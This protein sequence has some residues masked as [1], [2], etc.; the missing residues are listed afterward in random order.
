MSNLT[1]AFA[2]ILPPSDEEA[3]RQVLASWFTASERGSPGDVDRSRVDP[4]AFNDGRRRR[5]AQAFL[6]RFDRGTSTVYEAVRE[7]VDEDLRE[8]VGELGRAWVSPVTGQYAAQVVREKAARRHDL[9]QAQALLIATTENDANAVERARKAL[10]SPPPILGESVALAF[11]VAA[12]AAHELCE[13]VK[14]GPGW[15]PWW[16]DALDTKGDGVRPGDYALIAAS[17]KAG[18][19]T[20]A[21][22]HAFDTAT[23]IGP[24][25]FLSYEMTPQQ[26]T[27]KLLCRMTGLRDPRNQGLTKDEAKMVRE[28]ADAL[29]GVPIY[30]PPNPPRHIRALVP[31]LRRV[32]ATE[33]PV[34][35][36]ID[37]LGLI[38]GPGKSE[39][40][41]LSVIS[42]ELRG[43]AL[44]TG[45]PLIVLHQVNR[46]AVRDN[47]GKSQVPQLHHLRGSGQLEQDATHVYVLWNAYGAATQSD[48]DAGRVT[49]GETWLVCRKDRF[50]PADGKVVMR[51]DGARSRLFPVETRTP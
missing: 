29:E 21:L 18:K 6:A 24:T 15:V 9:Q 31:W 36:Y 5:I 40:E 30:I 26:L 44:T 47:A 10:A 39:Y 12:E 19:T 17:T 8:M 22:G 46:D 33:R 3:E 50:G 32:I 43:L 51:L 42:P 1:T 27:R 13:P 14:P 49:Q 35:V 4:S 25:V 28:A 38:D 48:R 2:S 16:I 45:V 20:F 7:A 11:S 41:R 34:A 23:K 37:Y